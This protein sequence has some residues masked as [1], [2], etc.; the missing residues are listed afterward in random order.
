ME[1]NSLSRIK[2]TIIGHV[3]DID[4]KNNVV[5]F[6]F[7]IDMTKFKFKYY[8]GLPS[9]IFYG[10]KKSIENIKK[11][12]NI[13]FRAKST[14]NKEY[15]INLSDKSLRSVPLFIQSEIKGY[16]NY[17]FLELSPFSLDNNVDTFNYKKGLNQISVELIGNIDQTS[18]KACILLLIDERR[19]LPYLYLFKAIFFLLIAALLFYIQKKYIL[20][21]L[22]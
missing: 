20:Q 21:K 15:L 10:E 1:V 4:K 12:K 6:K 13:I 2:T 19:I 9:I 7:N 8:S 18:L 3:S 22:V 5:N 11:C 17:Y 14:N 16:K